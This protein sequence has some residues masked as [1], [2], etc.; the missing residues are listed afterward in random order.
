ME[1]SFQICLILQSATDLPIPALGTVEKLSLDGFLVAAVIFL[2][3]AYREKDT[4]LQDLIQKIILTDTKQNMLM[5]QL[6]IVINRVDRSMDSSR[7][8]DAH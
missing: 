5:D 2:W 3:R 8:S 6:L 7:R 1:A 4:Q